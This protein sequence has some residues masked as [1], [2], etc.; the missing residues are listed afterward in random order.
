MKSLL[1]TLAAS[2]VAISAT[3]AARQTNYSELTNLTD[4]V[5]NGLFHGHT[6]LV[7]IDTDGRLEL[8]AQGRAR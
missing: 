1:I 7:D 6:I 2:T 5:S 4:L 8:V 3:G